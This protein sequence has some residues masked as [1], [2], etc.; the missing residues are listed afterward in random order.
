MNILNQISAILKPLGAMTKN[1][2]SVFYDPNKKKYSSKRVVKLLGGGTLITEGSLIIFESL[3]FLDGVDKDYKAVII[4]ASIGLVLVL[5]GSIV[6]VKGAS[7]IE[8][9]SRESVDKDK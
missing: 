4:K 7:A 2:S 8:N 3:K 1:I 9:I 6:G 5:I